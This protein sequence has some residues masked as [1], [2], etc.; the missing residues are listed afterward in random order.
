MS[1]SLTNF[2]T[3]TTKDV[4]ARRFYL[5]DSDKDENLII[6]S[7]GSSIDIDAGVSDQYKKI[8]FYT[9]FQASVL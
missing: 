9:H 6:E 5:D 8:R 2:G 4:L 1:T 7:V 3:V